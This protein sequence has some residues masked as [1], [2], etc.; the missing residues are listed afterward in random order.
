MGRAR[1]EIVAAAASLIADAGV[2]AVTM[3]AVARTAGVAKATVY[4]HVRDRDELLSAVQSDQSAQ[5]QQQVEAQPPEQRLAAAAA[6]LGES[7]VLRGLRLHDPHLVLSLSA[8]AISDPAVLAVVGS[9][10]PD[11]SDPEAALRWL[12]SF[13]VSPAPGDSRA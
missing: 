8:S 13:A 3:A 6:W 9:W 11:G 4:N 12:V 10:T 7:P 5:L 2:H 1:H